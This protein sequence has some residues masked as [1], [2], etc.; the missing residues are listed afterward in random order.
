MSSICRLRISLKAEKVD[1][2]KDVSSRSGV[3]SISFYTGILHCINIIPATEATDLECADPVL[4]PSGDHTVISIY[5]RPSSHLWLWMLYKLQ[6]KQ[7]VTLFRT[8]LHTYMP[9]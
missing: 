4:I 7:S 2:H 9:S 1:L 5:P 3:L 8:E 6:S